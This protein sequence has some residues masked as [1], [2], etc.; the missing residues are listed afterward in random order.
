MKIRY[1]DDGRIVGLYAD[2]VDVAG[3]T[4]TVSDKTLKKDFRETFAQGKYRVKAGKIVAVRG[5]RKTSVAKLVK[6]SGIA[7]PEND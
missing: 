4:I 5:F 6:M 3:Q 1:D 2:H 7:F